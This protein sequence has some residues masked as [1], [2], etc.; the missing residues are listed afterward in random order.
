MSTKIRLNFNVD[1]DFEL[2]KIGFWLPIVR[3]LANVQFMLPNGLLGRKHK[4]I[5]DTGSPVTT[6]PKSIWQNVRTRI[7]VEQTVHFGGIGQGEISGQIAQVGIAFVD[8]K[9]ASRVIEIPAFLASDDQTPLI[10]GFHNVL[11]EHKL[12][13]DYKRGK[14]ILQIR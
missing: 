1:V 12:M 5:L 9:R 14:A 3:V 11:S 2:T 10:V 6:I 8:D 7:L 13:C 4:A